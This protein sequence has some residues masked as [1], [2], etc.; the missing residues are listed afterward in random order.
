MSMRE[1][2][3][4]GYLVPVD[5]FFNLLSVNTIEKVNRAI[6][7]CDV[8]AIETLLHAAL[9]DWIPS[10]DIY[11]TSDTDTLDS[12]M[13]EGVYAIFSEEDLYIKQPTDAL[14]KMNKQQIIPLSCNWSIYG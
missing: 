14:I 6:E 3:Q 7:D 12:N 11:I 10:F 13:E 5:N 1:Y 8:D 9:P 4:H 2:P